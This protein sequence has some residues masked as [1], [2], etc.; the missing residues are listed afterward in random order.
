MYMHIC[1]FV[2]VRLQIVSDSFQPHGLQHAKASPTLTISW[3]LSKFMYIELVMPSNHLIL[4][5]PVLLPSI[6]SSIRV[7]P[8]SQLSASIGQ[9]TGASTSASILPINIQGWFLLG[10]TGLISFQSKGLARVFF[11]TN[12]SKAS[13]LWHS[14]FIMVQLS[15][16]YMTTGK[17]IPLKSSFFTKHLSLA[18]AG[19]LYPLGLRIKINSGMFVVIYSPRV[20]KSEQ[21]SGPSW[22]QPIHSWRPLGK[23]RCSTAGFWQGAENNSVYLNIHWKDWCWN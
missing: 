7:S 1:A 5:R 12:S 15:H 21:M 22:T 17:T 23:D 18:L 2:I 6:F 14:A 4:C 13:I 19:L 20:L 8:V 3:I 11:N 16:P 10:L 9:H